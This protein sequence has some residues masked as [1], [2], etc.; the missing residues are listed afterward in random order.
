MATP[1]SLV[2][3]IATVGGF[4]MISRVTGFIRDVLIANFLGA[5]MLADAFFVAFKLPNLFR[6]LFA[7]GAFNVAFV[8]LFSEFLETDGREKARR[9][10]EE[11]FSA[12]FYIV[13][14]FTALMEIAMPFVVLL[15][16]PGFIEDPAKMQATVF[17]SRVTFPYLL[18][19]SLNSL[20]SGMLNSVGKFAAA[21]LTPTLLNLTMIAA[22][23]ALTPLTGGNYAHALSAGVTLAG[24]LQLFWLIY[25]TRREGLPL[26][27]LSPLNTLK[28][29][30]E[31]VRL[32][33]KRIL[34]GVFGSGIYQ[35]NLFLDTLFVSFLTTGAVSW[36]YYANRLYQLPVGI[37]GAA[38][39]TALLPV[40]T[41]QLKS[42]AE[43]EARHSLNR[44]LEVALLLSVPAA[45]GLIALDMPIIS[46]LFVRG[47][48]T[49]EAAQ[50]TGLAL[51]AYALGL[52]AYILTKA[53]APVFYARGDTAT[54]VRIAAAALVMYI[55]LCLLLLPVMGYVGIALATGIV[56]WLNVMQYV[57][58]IYRKGLH[59]TDAA[60]RYRSF[61][62][63][64]SSVGMGCAVKFAYVWSL[65]RFPGWLYR[66]MPVKAAI[67]CGLVGLGAGLFTVFVFLTGGVRR[68]ELKSMLARRRR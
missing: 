68:D 4:T 52:P 42:G 7:E 44:A 55:L 1:H 40:L 45:A 16:A 50:N 58:L 47:K 25:H 3:S 11:A 13:L 33:L 66:T 15:Q 22:L 60:F 19:V 5:G 51:S 21:A 34:P 32:L 41:R 59:R 39:G 10:A 17:M 26:G 28:R 49:I 67:L 20:Q 57:Y 62:I 46:V 12:L 27:L 43:E 18:L 36:L 56:A 61:A 65:V 53:L 24:F 31:E 29:R 38:I 35:I 23:F 54:P 6:S 8:P 2:K 30:S 63:V 14:F 9:F 64:L 48:F 37:I